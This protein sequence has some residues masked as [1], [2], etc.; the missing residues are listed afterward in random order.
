MGGIKE[1][2]IDYSPA[3][4]E[5]IEREIAKVERRPIWTDDKINILRDLI[6]KGLHCSGIIRIFKMK[7]PEDRN[8]SRTAI[9]KKIDELGLEVKKL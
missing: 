7:Y 5:A 8:T 9:Q 1:T 6:K 2:R 3:I 4:L